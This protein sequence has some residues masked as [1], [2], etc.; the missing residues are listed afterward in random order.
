MQDQYQALV[1]GLK[2]QQDNNVT[3]NKI[4]QSLKSL[5]TSKGSL[6]KELTKLGSTFSVK[7]LNQKLA[8]PIFH[9]QQILNRPLNRQAIIRQVEL[10]IDNTTVV[11]A[12]SVL[13]LS[14][15]KKT[16]TGLA[17]LGQKPLGHLLF[18]KGEMRVS[19]R[20]FAEMN[21]QGKR[22]YARRTPYQYMGSTILVS[23][24]FLPNIEQLLTK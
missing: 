16:Q 13:P 24:Y 5:V 3:R 23:E 4:D 1:K 10:R 12:R 20:Q 14:L 11:F 18:K 8:L 7:V 6:T 21:Y 9:E 22:I 17:N 2:W 19:K 15:I